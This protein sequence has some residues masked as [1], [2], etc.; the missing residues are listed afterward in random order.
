MYT[1]GMCGRIRFFVLIED[2]EALG[3]ILYQR[4]PKS[5]ESKT[6]WQNK[7]RST[8]YQDND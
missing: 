8:R 1:G 6:H 5:M 7:V 3:L 2:F 4:T